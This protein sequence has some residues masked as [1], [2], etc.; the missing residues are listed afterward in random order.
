MSIVARCWSERSKAQ[1]LSKTT[2]IYFYSSGLR[3]ALATSPFLSSKSSTTT[4][5]LHSPATLFPLPHP[6][7]ISTCCQL[8]WLG[9]CPKCGALARNRS[10]STSRIP[11]ISQDLHETKGYSHPELGIASI[12]SG[13]SSQQKLSESEV[14]SAALRCSSSQDLWD[15]ACVLLE[16][17]GWTLSSASNFPRGGHT[18][19]AGPNA[20]SLEM[21]SLHYE[22]A[23]N[24]VLQDSR[25][26]P[27][28]AQLEASTARHVAG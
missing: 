14:T 6:T 10:I 9:F 23:L 16:L 24:S 27:R 11:S 8:Q 4:S 3:Q 12:W 17:Q 28:L 20:G 22:K 1:T 7:K 25:S 5:N 26:S 19:L 21:L 18:C 15:V 2:L 13:L